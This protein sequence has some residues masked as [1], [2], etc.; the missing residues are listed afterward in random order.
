M[1]TKIVHHIRDYVAII[2]GVQHTDRPLQ[3]K[4]WGGSGPLRPLRR[5]RL[6]Q[7]RKETRITHA[8]RP[9]RWQWWGRWRE[10]GVV[11]ASVTSS[12]RRRHPCPSRP[13]VRPSSFSRVSRLHAHV[14]VYI[15]SRHSAGAALYQSD[16]ERTTWQ[17]PGDIGPGY[18]P[19][20][21]FTAVHYCNSP[22]YG[23]AEWMPGYVAGRWSIERH[24]YG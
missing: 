5:W 4:Y 24:V 10:D 1:M 9:K 17:A 16:R 19:G 14:P 13:S 20:R 18:R 23:H 8:V 7:E 21:I 12:G 15:A 22:L 6:W 2:A 11:S 3:V